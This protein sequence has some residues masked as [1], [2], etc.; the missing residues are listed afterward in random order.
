MHGRK[1]TLSMKDGML[2]REGAD[3][4]EEK[5]LK[6]LELADRT[7]LIFPK[8]PVAPGDSWVVEGEEVRRFLASDGDLKEAK[9]KVTLLE[10][11]E[12]DGRRCAVLNALIELI[13]K[14][15]GTVAM[16]SENA[17]FKMSG[18]GPM[19]LERTMKVE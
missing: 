14:A 13:G 5:Q 2:L 1:I 17:Q 4:L 12:I 3:G 16:K 8:T 7:G 6:K 10:V 15:K 9:I 18:E 11:K 19:I